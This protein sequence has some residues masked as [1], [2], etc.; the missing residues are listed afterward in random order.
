MI[1]LRKSVAQ[2]HAPL[3]L[4]LSGN[5]MMILARMVYSGSTYYGFLLWNLFLAGM[6]LI[7][8]RKMIK[9]KD[10]GRL[11]L[12]LFLAVWLLFLPNAPYIIT[13]LVHLRHRSPVPYWYDMLLVM[14]S[15]V[16][17]LILG[18]TSLREVEV[19]LAGKH[20]LNAL[21]GIRIF[22]FLLLGYGVYMG[23]YLRFNSWDAFFN[24]IAVLRGVAD[25]LDKESLAFTLTFSF[26][27]YVLY[28]FF[29]AIL[30]RR[31]QEVS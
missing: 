25:S 23:R 29:Q 20:R 5:V 31:S 9:L 28:Q 17:G 27:N 1:S 11:T 19:Y 13:D 14:L 12:Y 16:N 3:V 6:P 2:L 8:S 24:P 15:A 7:I 10:P 21:E 18:F 30:L 22:V 4:A 26:V